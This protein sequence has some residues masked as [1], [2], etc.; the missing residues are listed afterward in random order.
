MPSK[1]ARPPLYGRITRKLT[2]LS[3]QDA[4]RITDHLLSLPEGTNECKI[5]LSH[6]SFMSADAPNA[7][8][9]ASMQFYGQRGRR[10][11]SIRLSEL[12]L[13]FTGSVPV[14]IIEPA[15]A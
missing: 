2:A 10:G 11:H 8:L 12:K 1:Y 6:T 5:T 15:A 13:T 3:P 9:T 4:D 14:V 7:S